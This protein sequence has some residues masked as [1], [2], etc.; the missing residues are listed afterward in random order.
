M[1]SK[2]E[3]TKKNL[4][5]KEWT[6]KTLILAFNMYTTNRL[7]SK[8]IL[9]T[10]SVPLL[11]W[12]YSFK[13]W[14]GKVEQSV[15]QFYLMSKQVEKEPRYISHQKCVSSDEIKSVYKKLWILI[16]NIGQSLSKL[17]IHDHFC[18]ILIQRIQIWWKIYFGWNQKRIPNWYKPI[19]CLKA[20]SVYF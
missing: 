10:K 11:S 13:S 19:W 9:Y 4:S 20:S 1:F 15:A 8:F 16:V 5:K 7:N 12:E 2:K 14:G 17:W 3:W 18:N 6:K